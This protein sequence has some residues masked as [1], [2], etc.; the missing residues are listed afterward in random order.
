MDKKTQARRT[1]IAFFFVLILALILGKFIRN[2]KLGIILGL[3][4]GGG[5]VFLGW[6]R[7]QKND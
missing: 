5:I 1:E 6:L 4:I 2:I 3:I 7:S